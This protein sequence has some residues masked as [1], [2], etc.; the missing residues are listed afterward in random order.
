MK[1]SK[2]SKK[3]TKI[4][5]TKFAS[6]VAK[7]KRN[8]DLPVSQGQFEEFRS[9]VNYKFTSVNLEFK[10]LR[11]DMDSKFKKVDARFNEIDAR[12]NEME[13][14]FKKIDARFDQ[15]EARFNQMEARFKQIDAR[16]NQLE[17]Q[18]SNLLA[19]VHQTR[20]IVEEQN[21]RNKFVLDGFANLHANLEAHKK[22]SSEKFEYIES[23]FK[24]NKS[25]SE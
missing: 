19:A 4:K 18:I 8:K 13:A 5:S 9:E 25:I 7:P 11:K 1:K 23:L 2:I 17:A 10:S 16:F 20:M 14:R 3:V 22:E 6:K 24:V 12:F 21:A 15:M